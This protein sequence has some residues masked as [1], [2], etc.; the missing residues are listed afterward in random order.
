[1]T[2]LNLDLLQKGKNIPAVFK[3]LFGMQQPSEPKEIKKL[4]IF[5]TSL[6]EYQREAVRFV[7][8]SPEISL[9]HGPPG[10]I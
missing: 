5:D 9:I 8:G 2:A 10:K 3:V 4:K 7:L 1:M 6:N